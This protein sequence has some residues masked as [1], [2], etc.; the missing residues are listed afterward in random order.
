MLRTLFEPTLTGNEAPSEEEEITPEQEEQAI[1]P[2]EPSVLDADNSILLPL[3]LLLL[4]LSPYFS[5]VADP[6]ISD[7]AR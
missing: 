7:G 5:S 6:D 4:L 1:L 3:P 2:L